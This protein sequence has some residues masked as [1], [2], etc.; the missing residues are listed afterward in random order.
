MAK[1]TCKKAGCTVADTGICLM[2][3]AAP[4]KQC[5]NFQPATAIASPESA[6]TVGSAAPRPDGSLPRASDVI[7]RFHTGL[8]LGTEDAITVSRASYCHLIGIL[9][10]SDAG[11]TCFLLSLY[12][13]ASRGA[14]PNGYRF[15]G[16]LTL[17]GFEDRAR[18]IRSWKAGP[19]P[20]QLADHTTL[21]DSRQA[22]LLHLALRKRG[23]LGRRIDLMLTDLPG[24]WSTTLVDRVAT[25]NRFHFLKRADG[26]IIVVD[27]PSLVSPRRHVEV[28]RT[29][30]LLERLVS[31]VGVDPTVPLT[32][33]LTKGDEIVMKR[34]DAASELIQ[35][36][37]SLGFKP[38]AVMS[39]AFSRT[40]DAVPNG[41]GV[42]EALERLFTFRSDT[43]LKADGGPAGF[44]DDREFAMYRGVKP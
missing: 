21:S 7:R 37:Q 22:A 10:A 38:E 42:F 31:D 30:H 29:K 11:K 35:H 25:A 8:E 36:S 4:D 15:A 34:P 41:T 28:Q 26:I 43:V 32:I 40:P 13:M 33:L 14:M 27:G 5:P 20:S 19:L 16:S 12:L 24:E 23:N 1:G 17:K 3:H 2:S 44:R 39:A 18:R 6:V 9:G